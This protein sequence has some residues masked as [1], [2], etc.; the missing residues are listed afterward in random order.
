MNNTYFLQS[1]SLVEAVRMKRFDDM[2]YFLHQGAD[3]NSVDDS[4]DPGVFK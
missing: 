4:S 1:S 3:V 2:E